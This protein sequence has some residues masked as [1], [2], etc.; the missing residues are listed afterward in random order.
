MRLAKVIEKSVTLIY[1]CTA[2]SEEE[3]VVLT[4]FFLGAGKH[5]EDWDYDYISFTCPLCGE[6]HRFEV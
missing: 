1:K 2:E 5:F 4:K 6:T 3:T